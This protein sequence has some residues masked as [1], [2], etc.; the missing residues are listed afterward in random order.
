MEADRITVTSLM[1]SIGAVLCVELAAGLVAPRSPL[2]P[3]VF[4]GIVRLIE[5]ALL[6]AA[7]VLG[8]SGWSSIGL[9]RVNAV[10]G[11]VRGLLW[12]VGFGISACIV[13]LI[14][15]AVGINGMTLIHASLPRSAVPIA[16]LFLVGGVI[17]PAAEEIFFRGIL[18]GFFRRWGVFVALMVSTLAFIVVHPGFPRIPVTHLVGGVVFAVAYEIEG[19]LMAPLTIHVL[20]NTAIFTLSLLSS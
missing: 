3:I 5:T 4:M 11:V 9:A 20:G 12:S 2:N 17:G 6:V 13:H 19:S 18:Y 16:L 14:L 15:C 7:V 1:V 8:G 10:H